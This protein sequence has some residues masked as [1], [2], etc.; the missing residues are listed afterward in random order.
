M[1]Q[2]IQIP[3]YESLRDEELEHIGSVVRDAV[4]SLSAVGTPAMRAS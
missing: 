4:L 3:I 2:S 1:T